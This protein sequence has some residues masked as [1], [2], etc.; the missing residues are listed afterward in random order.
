[1]ITQYEQFGIQSL[2]IS[3]FK[4]PSIENLRRELSQ[5]KPDGRRDTDADFGRKIYRG[6]KKD[7]TLWEKAVSWFGYK[8]HLVVDAH[9]ELPVFFQ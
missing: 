7:G 6:H 1:M 3:Y 5:I 2:W 8:F 9:Y 4:H